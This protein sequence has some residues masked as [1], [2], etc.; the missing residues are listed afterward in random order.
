MKRN[1]EGFIQSIICDFFTREWME[2]PW[3]SFDPDKI[4]G[5]TGNYW[6]SLYKLEKQF[7]ETPAP[8][9]IAGRV[10]CDI[11]FCVALYLFPSG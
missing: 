7:T 8:M 2:G 5:E 10:G 3:G 4:E 1:E 6:R 9:K 11:F